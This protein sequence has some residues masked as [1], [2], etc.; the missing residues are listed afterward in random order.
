VIR[1]VP[2]GSASRP[3]T[4]FSAVSASISMATAWRWNSCPRSVTEKRR[5]ERWIRRTPRCVSSAATRLARVDLGVP[6]A[7]AAGANPPRSTTCTK[8]E[9][10]FRFS[11]FIVHKYGR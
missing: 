2:L 8:K 3:F 6:V 10:S 9:T 11:I 4:R 5:E 1:T 7:R